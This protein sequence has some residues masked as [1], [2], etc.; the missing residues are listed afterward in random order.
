M[1]ITVTFVMSHQN[2]NQI[3]I[4][5]V[6]TYCNPN[7]VFFFTHFHEPWLLTGETSLLWVWLT[8]F[9]LPVTDTGK[10]TV[11]VW[12]CEFHQQ[13]ALQYWANDYKGCNFRHPRQSIEAI[14]CQVPLP[15]VDQYN[16]HYHLPALLMSQLKATRG[17][18][19]PLFRQHLCSEGAESHWSLE[20]GLMYV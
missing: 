9:P 19:S 13:A 4:S 3:I 6:S 1:S 5:H 12:Q 11:Y 18:N 8:N 10:Q 16:S 15:I 20:I 2:Q 14:T 17:N 7:K